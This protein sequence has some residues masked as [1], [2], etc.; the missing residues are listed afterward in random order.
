M[1]LT[2]PGAEKLVSIGECFITYEEVFLWKQLVN[3]QQIV[4]F[5]ITQCYDN[6]CAATVIAGSADE[7]GIY[8]TT[9][10]DD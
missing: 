4:E 6:I 10:E 3:F 9:S 8:I 2:W 7:S 1:T 5:R